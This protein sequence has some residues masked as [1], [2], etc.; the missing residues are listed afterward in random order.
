MSQQPGHR[1]PNSGTALL[2]EKYRR[3]NRVDPTRDGDPEGRWIAI[4]ESGWDG[5]QLLGASRSRYLI[6]GSVAISDEDALPIV[7]AIR[8]EARIAS[9]ELK[10][11]TS[12]ARDGR[13]RQRGVLNEILRH[14]GPLG[15]R[16]SVYVVDKQYVVVAKLIDLFVETK[17]HN[18]GVDIR[19]TGEA[20]KLARTLFTDGSRALGSD[21]FSDLLQAAVD[22]AASKNRG[23]SA[24]EFF[25]AVEKAWGRSHRRNVSEVLELLRACRTEIDAHA[26]DVQNGLWLE[27]LEPLFPAVFAMSRLWSIRIGR[28]N[29]LTDDQKVLTDRHLDQ[30]HADLSGRGI[31]EF[32]YMVSQVRMG[33]LVRGESSRHP[34]LQLADLVAGAGFQVAERHAGHP[35]PAG[36]E[37]YE[38]IIPMI[39]ENSLVPY[40]DPRLMAD[41]PT[42]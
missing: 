37:L 11:S 34:S 28:V 1:P 39:E 6:I 13:S 26:L 9:A 32:R 33:E 23:T 15:S 12:F 16:A 14:D 19:N 38:A 17:A 21:G 35:S 8:R 5:E 10:F 30:L 36:E 29:V 31:Q 41:V 7:E 25:N 42:N 24:E 3:R 18:A 2:G 20:R 40:D 27:A 22:F 4:D